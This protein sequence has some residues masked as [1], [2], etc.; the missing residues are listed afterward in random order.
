MMTPN[1]PAMQVLYERALQA[2][3]I[4]PLPVWS[5][6]RAAGRMGNQNPQHTPGLP[7]TV[8]RHELERYLRGATLHARTAAME[9]REIFTEIWTPHAS[10]S[11][12][13]S[14]TRTRF[15]GLWH[16][17]LAPALAHPGLVRTRSLSPSIPPEATGTPS[18]AAVRLLTDRLQG[19][20]AIPKRSLAL[21]RAA[22]TA[23]RLFRVL[24][25][26]LRAALETARTARAAAA[27]RA[28]PASPL[29]V[30][31]AM[32]TGMGHSTTREALEKQRRE[33]GSP[34]TDPTTP[35]AERQA[36][37]LAYLKT[38]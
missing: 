9:Y 11:R 26:E 8:R 24:L 14:S 17:V 13:V 37:A 15:L 36:L 38:L 10:G 31:H 5:Y 21:A 3:G 29:A 35:F 33:S 30:R 6:Q 12:A 23:L 18:V 25:R 1:R 2:L 34:L 32:G 16:Q 20:F 19:G 7:F 28:N 4:T 27:M 22:V